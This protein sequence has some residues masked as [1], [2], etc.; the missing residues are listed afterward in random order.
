MC[1]RYQ[2]PIFSHKVACCQRPAR[3]LG[4]RFSSL[5]LMGGVAIAMANPLSRTIE[6]VNESGKK[7]V[8]D[9]VH[10]KTGEVMTLSQ[11][12][13]NG[14][15]TTLHTYVNHTFLVHEP[16]NETCAAE[17]DGRGCQVRYIT[18]NENTEQGTNSSS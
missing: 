18:V 13:E 5:L 17:N 6:V 11:G 10:P 4:S 9:W 2:R 1:A 7:L 16:S 12:L 15:K 14:A 3:M 8:V